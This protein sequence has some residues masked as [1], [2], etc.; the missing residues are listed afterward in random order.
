LVGS[1][2]QAL[3][4]PAELPA[5]EGAVSSS[6]RLNNAEAPPRLPGK[7]QNLRRKSNKGSN[8]SRFGLIDS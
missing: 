3:A 1:K 4:E 8:A 7:T 6:R 5:G 2:Q